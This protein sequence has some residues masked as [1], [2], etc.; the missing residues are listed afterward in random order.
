VPAGSLPTVSHP[1]SPNA[2]RFHHPVLQSSTSHSS[3]VL[4]RADALLDSLPVVHS[5]HCLRG[6]GGAAAVGLLQRRRYRSQ[7]LSSLLTQLVDS[8]DVQ[9]V[10]C[11]LTALYPAGGLE[12]LA[13][14]TLRRWYAAYVD[15]L[16]R[17]Q[18]F[19]SAAET[20]RACDD[21]L[22]LQRSAKSSQQLSLMCARCRRGGEFGE[23]GP[24]CLHCR[25]TMSLC[26]LCQ[27]PVRGVF[28]WCQGCGHGGHAQHMQQWFSEFS[29]CP[30]GCL[31]RCVDE[32]TTA[33][34][35]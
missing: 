29:L 26:A 13:A 12:G 30:T 2:A 21:V 28:A 8:G 18:L 11:L 31:H 27:L 19:S 6:E 3:S 23:R 7:L 5:S 4:S 24:Y 9:T 34:D 32:L 33:T 17:L 16:T 35:D 22:Q 20:M 14:E 25:Q 1:S 10:C 15:Q